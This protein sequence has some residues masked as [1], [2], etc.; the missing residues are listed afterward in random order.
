MTSNGPSDQPNVVALALW[1]GC[2]AGLGLALTFLVI[3]G[4]SYLFLLL[5]GAGSQIR[6][7]ITV[8]SGPILGTGLIL[9]IVLLRSI[10]TQQ[11]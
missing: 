7:L 9:L 3:S 10:G 2:L 1:Q 6:L 8:A 11:D 4:L 5:V